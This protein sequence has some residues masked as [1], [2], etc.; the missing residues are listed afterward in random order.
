MLTEKLAN[1]GRRD[2]SAAE[3]DDVRARP[4]AQ[5]GARDA[6]LLLAEGRLAALE[7]LRDREL[8][9]GL[10]RRPADAGMHRVR[11]RRLAGA[12]EADERDVLVQSRSRYA[13]H[14]A[15]KSPSRVAAELLASGARELPGDRR[16]RDDRERL[17]RGHVA[18]LD[19]RRRGLARGEVDGC[20]RLHERRQRLH[21]RAHDDLLAVRHAALDAAGA[22]RRAPLVGADLVV[23]L[24]SAQLRKREAVADLDALDRLDAHQRRGEPRVEAVLAPRVRAEA[25]RNAG[26]AHLDRPAE[27]VAVLARRVDGGRICARDRQRLARH[28][29]ADLGEQRLRHRTGGDVHRRVACGRALERVPHVREAVLL[30]AGQVGVAGPRQRHRLRAL[31]LRLALG[32]PRAP[33]P[34]SSSCGRG[35]GRRARAACRACGRA[36]ARRAP[37]PRPSRSAAGASGRS[38]AGGGAGRR[39]WLR[40]RG[41]APRAARRGSR[42]ARGR[43]T[44]LLWPARGSLRQA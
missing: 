3:I 6:R 31:A 34:T 40:G 4:G 19:E 17:H 15:T 43:A 39:R 5:H 37:P 27:R 23:R 13:R 7:Q 24:R 29:D 42:R 9:V 32:R 2:R 20:E 22:I 26:R 1:L 16:L 11:H 36:A 18:A 28:G 33:S 21:R 25:G 30:H 8:A 12:H 35:C 41:R 10:D 38:P 44:R 14:A